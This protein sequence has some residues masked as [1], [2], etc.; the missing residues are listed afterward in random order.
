MS[1][2]LPLDLT[3]VQFTIFQLYDNAKAIR[4]Q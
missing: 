1:D 4:I 2:G 3:I